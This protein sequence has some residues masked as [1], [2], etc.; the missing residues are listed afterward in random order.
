M[1]P[2]LTLRDRP[3]PSGFIPLQDVN[4]QDAIMDRTELAAWYDE[5]AHDQVWWAPWDRVLEGLTAEQA[6]WEPAPGRH[7]IRAIVDHVI[8]WRE[9]FVHRNRGGAPTT[10]ADLERRNWAPLEDTSEAAWERTRV[11]FAESH[12]L[13]R[14]AMLDP[15]V[16]PPPKPQLDLRYL[17]LHDTY[18]VGQIMTIRAL[19][20]LPPLET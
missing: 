1:R 11:R 5:A 7:S 20:G 9:Y 18:H 6:A 19:L 15:A 17:L 14:A 8:H 16:G 12:A 3:A 10:E 2:P 4:L 13:V